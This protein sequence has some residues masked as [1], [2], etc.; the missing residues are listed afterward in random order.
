[1]LITTESLF[2]QPIPGR[3]R[4][5]CEE[6]PAITA[7]AQ[8][9]LCLSLTACFLAFSNS[10]PAWIS[11]WFPS[12]EELEKLASVPLTGDDTYFLKYD[13]VDGKRHP[14]TVSPGWVDKNFGP[15][16]EGLPKRETW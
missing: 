16:S 3:E 13:P 8:M 7:N 10:Q 11:S 12:A 4:A 14:V 2:Y 9:M 1:M 15:A 6:W 5:H